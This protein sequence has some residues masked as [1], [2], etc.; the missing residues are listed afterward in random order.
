MAHAREEIVATNEAQF[1]AFNER[2]VVGADAGP[3]E[4]L[5]ECGV[6]SCHAPLTVE[7]DEYRDVRSDP[8]RFLVAAGHEMRDV[9]TV[10]A[11]R[12]GHLVVE[13][14]GEVGHIITSAGEDAVHDGEEEQIEE[15]LTYVWTS[16]DE[17]EFAEAGEVGRRLPVVH[18]LVM[19][20]ARQQGRRVRVRVRDGVVVGWSPA[21]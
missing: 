3:L 14:P 19:P 5:C 15:K 8:C 17:V 1:R 12:G 6:A 9:E 11:R 7:A 18:E 16:S 2:L 4:I 13:K 10:V 21:A 20:L